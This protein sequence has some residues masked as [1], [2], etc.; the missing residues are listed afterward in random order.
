MDGII[1][2]YKET[3]YT[4][5]DVVAKLRGILKERKMGHT[6]T[7]DPSATGVLPVCLGR[8]TRLCELMLEKEKTY[9]AKMLLG[10]TTDTEDLTGTVLDRRPVH[11][12][13]SELRETAKRFTGC[14]EQLPPMYSAVRMNG[15]HLYELVREGKEVVREPRSVEIFE[16]EPIAFEFSED[17]FVHSVTLR[18]RV[19]KGTYIRSL[20]RDMGEELLCGACTESLLRTKAGVFTLET[21]KTIDEVIDARDHGTLSSI[22]IPIDTMLSMHRE[23]S[24]LPECEKYLYNGNPLTSS[25]L[26]DAPSFH[27]EEGFRVY[28]TKHNIIGYYTF[29]EDRNCLVAKKMF[30]P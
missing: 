22:L 26:V 5:F 6:G 20:I 9:E 10:I 12:T 27:A 18:I 17:G 2:I 7:L 23:V 16:N 8:A 3:G 30:L 29:R 15:K 1:N 25:M 11:V 28:D 24:I 21:A 13:E 19:S 4:S 14:Y